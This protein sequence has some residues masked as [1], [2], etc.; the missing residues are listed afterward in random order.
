MRVPQSSLRP[1]QLQPWQAEPV[2]PVQNY[3]ANQLQQ[4]G[5]AAMRAGQGFGEIAF[6]E[7]DRLD[8]V[9]AV[10]KMNM[11]RTGLT[12]KRRAYR[13]RIG[14]DAVQGRE[15]ALDDLRRVRDEIDGM[16]GS[17]GERERFGPAAD[18][19]MADAISDIEDHYGKQFFAHE[20]AQTKAAIEL[21]ID[22]ARNAIRETGAW[23]LEEGNPDSRRGWFHTRMAE[24]RTIELLE[25]KGID[26]ASPIGKQDLNATRTQLAAGVIDDFIAAGQWNRAEQY[27][28]DLKPDEIDGAAYGKMRATVK[29]ASDSERGLRSAMSLI[30]EMDEADVVELR[31]QLGR[32]PE[33]QEMWGTDSR[34]RALDLAQEAFEN[35][36]LTTDGYKAAVA[37]INRTYEQ[38]EQIWH[39]RRRNLLLELERRVARNENIT[40]D[41]RMAKLWVE[42][43]QYGATDVAEKILRVDPKQ[44][45]LRIMGDFFQMA[46]NGE[47][48]KM[49]P[50]KLWNLFYPNA[51]PATWNYI[52]SVHASATRPGKETEAKDW[53]GD[54]NFLHLMANEHGLITTAKG[55]DDREYGRFLRFNDELNRRAEAER[56]QGM[57]PSNKENIRQIIKQMMTE[58]VKFDGWFGGGG[59]QYQWEVPDDQRSQFLGIDEVGREFSYFDI[60]EKEIDKKKREY[61]SATPPIRL[62]SFQAAAKVAE[63]REIAKQLREQRRRPAVEWPSAGERRGK[64][65]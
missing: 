4:F 28:N 42:L 52:Q 34:Q 22:E 1:M 18:Q 63:D 26:P 64:Y 46:E 57:D 45:D 15:A 19:V 14:N 48:A 50:E 49:S 17:R 35:R 27:F 10:E 65:K 23:K 11:L 60:P 62:T 24:R 44:T 58:K 39:E 29:Q 3:A 37:H 36:D 55:P 30:R 7:Q 20:V 40:D 41:P 21:D 43:E 38:R 2:Q 59:I 51:S 47:L 13:Q 9:A 6:E 54:K 25:K 8:K 33:P 31:R 53:L 5:Q 56:I 61:L 12:E 16:L 32:D